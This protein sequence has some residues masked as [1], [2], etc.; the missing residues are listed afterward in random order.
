MLLKVGLTC[1][2]LALFLDFFLSLC[3]NQKM[4]EPHILTTL[5][6]KR[7]EIEAVIAAYEAKIDAANLI[8]AP[9]VCREAGGACLVVV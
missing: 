1:I 7:A 6:R 2:L 9:V 8:T 3:H 4:G 5:R